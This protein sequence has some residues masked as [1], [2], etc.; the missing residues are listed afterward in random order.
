[1]P[2]NKPFRKAALDRLLSPEDLDQTIAITSPI[3]WAALSAFVLVIVAAL[4]WGFFGSISN[5][6][7]GNGLLLYG[8]DMAAI[9]SYTSGIITDVSVQNGDF[10]EKGQTIARVSQD[11]LFN[12]IE[13]CKANI[14]ALEGITVKTLEIDPKIINTNLY[15]EFSQIANQI[16]T[17]RTQYTTQRAEYEKNLQD[18]NN[19]LASK[20]S[21]IRALERQLDTAEDQLADYSKLLDYQRKL[22]LENAQAQQ[23]Q[24]SVTP[25]GEIYLDSD[26]KQYRR[27]Y[28]CSHQIPIMDQIGTTYIILSNGA[29]YPVFYRTQS[30]EEFNSMGSYFLP[31]YYLPIGLSGIDSDLIPQ[32]TVPKIYYD[33]DGNRYID[34]TNKE[35]EVV[36]ANQGTYDQIANRPKFDA[37]QANMEAQVQ[38]YRLQLKQA[39]EEAAQ[40]KSSSLDY[41]QSAYLQTEAQI[42]VLTKQFAETKQIKKADLEKQLDKLQD[43]V[44]ENGILK[45]SESGEIINLTIK[46][47]EAVNVGMEVGSIVRDTNSTSSTTVVLYVPVADGKKVKEGMEVHISPST[48]KP[49]EHGYIIGRVTSVSEYAVSQESMRR[50]LN[51]QQLVSL[52]SESA[53]MEVRVEMLRDLGTESGYKWSTPKGAPTTIEAGTICSGE[54]RVSSQR[55]IEL[56]I[57]FMKKLFY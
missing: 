28:T 6:V 18:Y 10:V 3:A 38:N 13:E 5:R 56:V 32:A 33:T 20:N 45:A 41:L 34:R 48:V 51:H 19:S 29:E 44:L 17:L 1:M 36:E 40:M 46:R 52:L 26:G 53:V 30:G 31:T 43:Q 8:D 14:D 47:G 15:P 2:S 42:A 4:V 37:T 55:P 23:S 35:F 25:A 9:I 39:R 24:G 22:E 50:T 57:P 49:D 54:I 21:Q 12:Q 16:K 7:E 27:T 11:E